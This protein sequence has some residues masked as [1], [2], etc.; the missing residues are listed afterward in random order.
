MTRH[1]RPETQQSKALL[2][3]G[4][5][6]FE[7]TSQGDSIAQEYDPAYKQFLIP[8]DGTDEKTISVQ[9]LQQKDM[10][11]LASFTKV[12]DTSQ[13]WS[14]YKDSH[15]KFIAFHPSNINSPEWI[16]RINA[17]LQNVAVFCQ[18]TASHTETSQQKSI[19]PVRYP[20]DQLLLI[21]LLLGKGLL[22]HAA[23]VVIDGKGF[24]FAGPSGA[25]KSTI[26]R[27]FQGFN[28]FTI[29]SDDRI[30]VQQIGQEFFMYGTPWPGE[31]GIA[32]NDSAKLH[33]IFFLKHSSE[34][35]IEKLSIS[36]TLKYFFKVASLPLYDKADM[37]K[38]LDFIEDLLKE[39]RTYE[40]YFKP[41]PE[42]VAEVFSLVTG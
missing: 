29:L 3:I 10:P 17:D 42:I 8:K 12:F 25:G 37:Q 28:N 33:G 21:N 15:D 26:C 5:L 31:A 14:M 36:E 35:K 6:F 24:L 11:N 2:N 9:L 7:I 38:S 40:L 1:N 16:A 4:P 30:V 23:G 32:V 20:L 22:I 13:S 27:L 41:G 34:N 39:V 19:N 18:T